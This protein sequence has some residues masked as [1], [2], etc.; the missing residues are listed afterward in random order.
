MDLKKDNILKLYWHYFLTSFGS[1]MIT[2]IYCLVDAAAVGKY[3]GPIGSSAFS[4]IA[5]LWSILISLGVLMGV[6]GSVLFGTIRGKR[7]QGEQT[8][9]EN[10]YFT[11]ALIGSIFFAVLFEIIVLSFQ[12]PI[13]RFFGGNDEIIPLAKEYIR[14]VRYC[15]PFFIFNQLLISFVRNDN[16][17]V[18]ATIAVVVGAVA[19]MIGDYV[20]VFPCNLGIYGAGL[21]TVFGS[22]LTLLILITHFFFKKNHLRLVYPHHFFKK[23]LSIMVNGFSTFFIDVAAGILTILFNR[24]IMSN[25]G[26][27]ALAVYGCIVNVVL[28]VQC[29]SYS[30]GQAAQPLI[31][32]NLGAQKYQR[33]KAL[34]KYSLYSVLVISIFWTTLSLFYPN[35]YVH[36]FMKPTSHILEI[37]PNI[38]RI[39]S[40]SFLLLPLNIFSTYYFQ[41]LL[42]PK[43]SFFISLLRGLV[44]S[45]IFVYTLPLIFDSNA[46]WFTMPLTELFVACFSIWKIFDF[47]KKLETTT[48]KKEE[49]NNKK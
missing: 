34:L 29:C 37:A 46:I 27:D 42:K 36:I 17:P 44:L 19:N 25:L 4:V 7:E 35:A 39:Y 32:I 26:A 10:E 22:L 28:F 48:P 49:N 45:S 14:A 3:H 30:V 41:A 8:I 33:I 9:D 21:A 31:S 16:N 11:V 15:F 5:P 6:G 23:F 40:L 43:S 1:A 13:F 24:Q 2:S 18:L 47:T 20:F 12:E 38:I